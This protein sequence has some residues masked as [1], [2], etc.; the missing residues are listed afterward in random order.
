MK[1]IIGLLF[2]VPFTHCFVPNHVPVSLSINTSRAS[3]IRV[4]ENTSS[5]ILE[6]LAH[7]KSSS[8]SL[9]D[10]IQSS[11]T[12]DTIQNLPIYNIL[13]SIKDGIYEKNNLLLQASP[14]A[15]KTTIVPLA[16]C[17]STDDDDDED[18]DGQSDDSGPIKNIIVV[19]PRRV[20]TR[21]A[22]Q[23]MA[24]IVNE[25]PGQSVGY[26]I[27]GETKVSN[28]TKIVVMTDGVLLNKLRDDPELSGVDAVILDEFHERGVG[29]DVALA[30][31]R[32]IQMNFRPELKIIVMSATL[33]GNDEDDADTNNGVDQ[34]DND[35]TNSSVKSKLLKVL[36]GEENCNVLRSEGRQFPITYQ[37]AKRSSPLHGALRNDMR[38]LVRTMSDAIEEALLKAPSK[39]DVLAFLPGAKEI[40]RVVQE[41]RSRQSS[42]GDDVDIFPLYG[43]LPKPEQDLAIYKDKSNSNN[44]R[45]RIIVSSPIAE[46]SLTIDGVTMVV[47][48][49]FRREP[50][51]DASTGLPRLVT[52]P[53]SKDSTIQRAGR[54]GRTQDGYCI[55]LFSEGE[56]SNFAQ[57]ALPEIHST[58]LIPTALLLSEWGYSS[59]NEIL[60]EIPFVDAPP[61]DALQKAYDVLID[62]KALEEYRIPSSRKP[63]YRVTPHGQS[64]HRLPTHP[65]F[66]SCIIEA[67]EASTDRRE[68]STDRREKLAAAVIVAG[69]MDGEIATGGDS[70]LATRVRD[71]L[72][73]GERTFKGSKIVQFASR[74]SN[75]ARDAVLSAMDGSLST[76]H[77]TNKIGEALLPGFIDVIGQHKGDASY[78]GSTYMLSLGR[79]A[80]LDGK[81]DEGSYII[82]VDTSTGDDGKIRIRAYAN[83][84]S[85]TLEDVATEKDELYT[86]ASRGY[87]VRARNVVKVGSLE[88]SSSPL[89]SPQPEEVSGILMDTIT[90]LG[91]VNKALLSMQSK[92][93][94]QAITDLRQRIRL[95]RKLTSDDEWPACFAALDKYSDENEEILLG[96]VEPWLAAAGSLKAV[97]MLQILESSIDPSQK[98]QLDRDYPRTIVAPDGSKIPLDYDNDPPLASAKLQQFFGATESPTVGPA[99]NLIPIALS[100]LSPSG[101]NKPLA[102]T[103]DLPF[104]WK[105]T[106]PAV[107]AEMRG[108]YPKHPWPEDPL[109]AEPTRLSKKALAGKN[110]S[111]ST[112]S[113][114][115]TTGA[116]VDKRKERSKQRKQRK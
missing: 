95:A 103:V 101:K 11:D 18:G 13:D 76:I 30:L 32:E 57:H 22:A 72:Q 49:G 73:G 74:L 24:S 107:R 51:Y 10:E 16:L 96:L 80:R 82:V 68:A 42:L 1:L 14:G 113:S 41:L 48:S 47:D 98:I 104:F 53:S 54:A 87:E 78:G 38:L 105:E 92:K 109:N 70:N 43:S 39:G 36:G 33:L 9:L 86:V 8:P 112:S 115:D 55:C 20:A 114:G 23:R 83:V 5:P 62:L 21:S 93:N 26:I 110:S 99:H 89:P 106:Y 116:A 2:L 94:I 17:S 108:R 66:A 71:I 37:Y 100:L 46:A 44:R 61:E 65:R 111:K 69:L 12:S 25:V 4:R 27:R 28:K 29:A 31:C 59:A 102:Q 52:V 79:S 84:D 88:L 19:E 40:R 35:E 15:G 85:D 45:R 67:E 64:L 77:V 63:R 56:M 34:N 58:D 3:I 75:E 7:H 81:R 97:D 6:L 60:N 91:G 50:R 90:S